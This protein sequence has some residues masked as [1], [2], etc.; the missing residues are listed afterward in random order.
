[1]EA[2]QRP[3][4]LLTVILITQTHNFNMHLI[5]KTILNNL[6][7]I[8]IYELLNK[9]IESYGLYLASDIRWFKGEDDDSV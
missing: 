8:D 5:Y 4:E 7:I 2:L 1:M 9:K 6:S 3:Q